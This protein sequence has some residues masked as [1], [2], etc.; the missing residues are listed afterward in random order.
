MAPYPVLYDTHSAGSRSP[1]PRTLNARSAE[2]HTAVFAGIAAVII[3]VLLTFGMLGFYL[4]WR[5]KRERLE[6]LKHR[7]IK[8][9]T[10]VGPRSSLQCGPFD[11]TGESSFFRTSYENQTVVPTLEQKIPATPPPVYSPHTNL[12]KS[13]GGSD[14]SLASSVATKRTYTDNEDQMVLVNGV[15]VVARKAENLE[16]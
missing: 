10:I 6:K 1:V 12:Q 16:V 5:Q 9:M 4:Y 13:V 3:I 15:Y 7:A 14:E 11:A 8:R 2:T